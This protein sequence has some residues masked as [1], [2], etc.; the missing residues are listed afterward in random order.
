VGVRHACALAGGRSAQ[1]GIWR[2]CSSLHPYQPLRGHCVDG[3]RWRALASFPK[4]ARLPRL[5]RCHLSRACLLQRGRGRGGSGRD[6]GVP[7][8]Q[9]CHGVHQLQHAGGGGEGAHGQH[10]PPQPQAPVALLQRCS[11][12]FVL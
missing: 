5:L 8:S 7:A 4:T 1:V 3:S 12:C 6:L 2:T 9:H 11:S 10:G